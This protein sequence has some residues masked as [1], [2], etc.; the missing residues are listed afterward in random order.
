MM[1]KIAETLYYEQLWE[2]R[3][4]VIWL[5]ISKISCKKREN[6]SIL[7]NTFLPFPFHIIFF[8]DIFFFVGVYINEDFKGAT[9]H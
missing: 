6:K 2:M 9:C 7:E 8:V 4:P 5:S 1:E 3:L